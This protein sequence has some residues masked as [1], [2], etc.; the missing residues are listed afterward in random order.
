MSQGIIISWIR[1][2]IWKTLS[3]KEV[4]NILSQP[5]NLTSQQRLDKNRDVKNNN[6]DDHLYSALSHKSSVRFT[7]ALDK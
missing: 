2:D 5:C 7:I 4:N 1:L 6:N 3:N